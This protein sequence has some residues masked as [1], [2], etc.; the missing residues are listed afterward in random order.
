[1]I[2]IGLTQVQMPLTNKKP[3]SVMKLNNYILLFSLF[4]GV[5]NSCFSQQ[6][7]F[8]SPLSS[9]DFVYNPAM[10]S[11][12]DLSNFGAFYRQQWASFQGAPRTAIAFAQHPVVLEK[13]SV[14]LFF[15]N[16]KYGTFD[17]NEFSLA[18]NYKIEIGFFNNDQLSIGILAGW[19]QMRFD[20]TQIVAVSQ[21]DPLPGGA[22]GFSNDA[23]FGAGFYYMSDKD[24][25]NN[26]ESSFF[27]GVGATQVI[28]MSTKLIDS[29][30]FDQ[31]IHTNGVLGGKFIQGSFILQ[32]TVWIDYALNSPI[33]GTLSFSA[34]MESAFWAG[35]AFQTD[36]T[37]SLFFGG[38]LDTGNYSSFRI[39][40]LGNYNIGTV[41]R[42]RGLGYEF[43]INYQVEL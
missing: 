17:H 25:V 33:S 42:Q 5:T 16:D 36:Q 29:G 4:I 6:I 24:M 14:G 43:T 7:E 38:I 35:L 12:G 28:P 1:M 31:T 23:N 3:K 34:E 32:P 18:Y 8:R 39:G 11:P 15:R 26:E 10:A 27:I 37:L 20:G 21:N 19:K 22:G 30:N 2:K 40:A 13:M 9:N 41:G